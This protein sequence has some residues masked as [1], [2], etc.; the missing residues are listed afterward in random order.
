MQQPLLLLETRIVANVELNAGWRKPNELPIV[1]F[2][3]VV[4]PRIMMQRMNSI[5][6]VNVS[7]T[8]MNDVLVTVIVTVV[9]AMI[10]LVV[11]MIIIAR[12]RLAHVPVL[13]NTRATAAVVVA[14]CHRHP[15]LL[16]RHR[17]HQ[18][19][20]TKR[21][22]DHHHQYDRKVH[23]LVRTPAFYHAFFLLVPVHTM[24]H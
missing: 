4:V 18:W 7:M 13:M 17:L 6:F 5:V 16:L 10:V 2:D 9:G 21:T 20:R 3:V 19:S 15:R 11:A 22:D 12:V 8:M 1:S 23:C 24:Q 14:M